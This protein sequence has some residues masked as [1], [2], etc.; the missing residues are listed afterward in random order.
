RPSL[1]GMV[2]CYCTLPILII[3]LPRWIITNFPKVSVHILKITVITA[4]KRLLRRLS[5]ICTCSFCLLHNSVNLVLTVDKISYGE[6]RRTLCLQ[7]NLAIPRQIFSFVETQH[8]S[9]IQLKH[10]HRTVFVFGTDNAFCFPTHSISIELHGFFQIIDS[11]CQEIHALVHFY[12]T[13]G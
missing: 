11:K 2:L 12:T 8:S 1:H 3:N 9:L 4:P 13:L 5:Y 7:C 10:Y 6:F